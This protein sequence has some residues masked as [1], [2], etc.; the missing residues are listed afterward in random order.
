ML[1]V[2]CEKTP[3]APRSHRTRGKP[4]DT[5]RLVV[6]LRNKS[7]FQPAFSP[8]WAA[9]KTKMNNRCVVDACGGCNIQLNAM[10]S[11][12]PEGDMVS[13]KDNEIRCAALDTCS[14]LSYVSLQKIKTE[15]VFNKPKEIKPLPQPHNGSAD[16]KPLSREAK[17]ANDLGIGRHL[18]PVFE[19]TVRGKYV[20]AEVVAETY[21][22]MT[23]ERQVP[24][25]CVPN[26][27]FAEPYSCPAGIHLQ[28]SPPPPPPLA[29]GVPKSP[30][31]GLR[32]KLLLCLLGGLPH[33]TATLRSTPRPNRRL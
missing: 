12:V 11:W 4:S 26:V 33:L 3:A 29:P 8:A 10:R 2:V 6:G 18:C 9:G 24:Q 23:C 28:S 16:S 21:P 27:V 20:V 5:E 15:K 25:D 30:N 19:G 7:N 14:W 13:F 17:L 31:E 32:P 22:T 1:A